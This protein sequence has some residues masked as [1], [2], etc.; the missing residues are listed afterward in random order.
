VAAVKSYVVEL[1][2]GDLSA[3]E[4][5]R[6]AAEAVSREGTA[7]RFVRSVHVPEYG[8]CLLVFEAGTPDAV[9]LAGRRAGLTYARIVEGGRS[10]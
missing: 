5:A 7:V 9:D 10:T 4:R 1:P 2:A 3:G 6:S 8:T